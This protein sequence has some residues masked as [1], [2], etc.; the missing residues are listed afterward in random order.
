MDVE[1]I[2]QKIIKIFQAE[3]KSVDVDNKT[4]TV[5]VSSNKVDRYGDVVLPE[6]FK[7]HLKIYKAHPVLLS[8]HDYYDLRKQIGE[9]KSVKITEEGL[10]ATFVYYAGE[11]NPEADWG[12]TLA[13]KK[14]A[15]F[16]IGFMG[17]DYEWIKEKDKDTGNEYITGRKF[18]EIELLEISQ[19]LVPANRQSV[20]ERIAYA[21]ESK[22]MAEL[23]VNA[24]DTGEL[25]EVK[26]VKKKEEKPAEEEQPGE[27]NG[28]KH[29]SES[30]LDDGAEKEASSQSS[31]S[32]V[33]GIV[34]DAVR[35]ALNIKG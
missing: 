27:G 11:G 10:E 33:Q 24:F 21:N 30:I 13:Q 5:L 12:W 18:T 35:S 8:S 1:K 25:N 7:K 20:Q 26:E 23:V 14:I 28:K 32:E 2:T 4:L 16:S 3:I 29:Y 31:K 22:K 34:K 17:L 6:A 9:A 15:S 19:V